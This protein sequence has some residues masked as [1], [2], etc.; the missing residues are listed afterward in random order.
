[1]DVASYSYT[2]HGFQVDVNKYERRVE[3]FRRLSRIPVES[4]ARHA[5]D[6]NWKSNI[7]VNNLSEVFIQ[8]MMLEENR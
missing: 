3:D 5:M 6:Y 4:W 2:K 1:M 7:V 8:M